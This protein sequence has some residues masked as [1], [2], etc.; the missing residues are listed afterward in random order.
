MRKASIASVGLGAVAQ[1]WHLPTIAE[2]TKKG[3]LNFIAVCDLDETKASETGKQY[4]SAVLY[5]CRRDA[6]RNTRISM[7]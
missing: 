6:S 7:S 1:R 3:D 2:L 4:G 5:R